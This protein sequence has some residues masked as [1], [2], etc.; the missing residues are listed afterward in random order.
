MYFVINGSEMLVLMI[1]IIIIMMIII[2][3][4][5]IMIV[6]MIVII[7]T[8]SWTSCVRRWE[9]LQDLHFL[10]LFSKFNCAMPKLLMV[11]HRKSDNIKNIISALYTKDQY[12]HFWTEKSLLLI[13]LNYSQKHYHRTSNTLGPFNAN[14]EG[15]ALK[16]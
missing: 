13:S 10:L 5:I 6:V 14:L 11:T 16:S 7:I 1:I 4:I 8:M 15:R 12:R 2:I 3:V 9:D